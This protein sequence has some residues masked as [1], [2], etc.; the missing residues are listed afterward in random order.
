MATDNFL[1]Q[2]VLIEIILNLLVFMY[3]KHTQTIKSQDLDQTDIPRD[4]V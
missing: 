2:Y 1:E 3:F 4:L